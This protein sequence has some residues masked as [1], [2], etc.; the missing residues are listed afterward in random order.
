MENSVAV[1]GLNNKQWI[2]YSL[3]YGYNVGALKLKRYVKLKKKKK[4]LALKYM[5]GVCK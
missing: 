4:K 2:I 1:I 5:D 3:C